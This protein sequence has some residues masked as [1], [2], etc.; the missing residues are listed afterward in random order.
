MNDFETKE[1]TSTPST[2]RKDD[3][4]KSGMKLREACSDP[5]C[6]FAGSW[7]VHE[8]DGVRGAGR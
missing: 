1:I 5:Q 7:H 4:V 6:Q 2:E 8:G 3:D